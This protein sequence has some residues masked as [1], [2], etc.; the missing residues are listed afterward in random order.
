VPAAI[1]PLEFDKYEGPKDIA[2][3]A[4]GSLIPLK[5]Y[6]VFVEIIKAIQ[7]TLPKINVVLIGDGPE[8]GRLQ[9]MITSLEL[10]DNLLVTG[11]LSHKQLLGYMQRAKLF[12]HPS[13]YEGFGVVCLEALYGGAQVISFCKPMK[14][15]IP[16]WRTVKTKD[17]MVEKA[18]NILLDNNSK[19]ERVLPYSID[20]QAKSIL[21]IFGL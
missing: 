18:F 7:K 20:D 15:E 13:S 4:A 10:T 1:D 19:S 6:E 17:E 9:S 8:R 14:N 5:Q 16:R 21:E 12:L 3:V 11:E 2:I